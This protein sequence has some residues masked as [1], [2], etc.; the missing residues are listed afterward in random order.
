MVVKLGL[1]AHNIKET[2]LT[3]KP[4][5]MESSFMPM[6]MYTKET[7]LMIK[8]MAGEYILMQMELTMKEIG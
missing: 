7:G 2:G 4:V 6:E 5:V 8:L 3:I 1:M